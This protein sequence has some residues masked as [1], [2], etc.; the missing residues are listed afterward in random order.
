M[1]ME[2]GEKLPELVKEITQEGINAY[3]EATGDFNPIHVD[4][5]FARNT[6][7]K[8]TIAH[9][10]YIFGFLSEL[11]TRHFNKR[12]TNSGRI[13]VRFKR[14]VRPGDTI[15]V[16]ATLVGREIIQDCAFLVFEIV[17][18]NQMLDPVIEGKAFIAE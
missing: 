2:I 5:N 16:K 10:F 15:K 8:G 1:K 6:P 9:G 4:E 13:D 3:A 18:E 12:W 11:M 17:W 14:P 7:F